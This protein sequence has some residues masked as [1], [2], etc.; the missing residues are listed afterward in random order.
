MLNAFVAVVVHGGDEL[1]EEWRHRQNV[2]VAVEC[3]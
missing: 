2:E 1:V 3:H